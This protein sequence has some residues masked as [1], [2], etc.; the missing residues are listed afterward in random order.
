MTLI[1]SLNC[2][3]ADDTFGT[4]SYMITQAFPAAVGDGVFSVLPTANNKG[5]LKLEGNK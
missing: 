5:Q 4:L 1:E 2:L 3:D